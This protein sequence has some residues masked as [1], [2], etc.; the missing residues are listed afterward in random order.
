[1]H[2]RERERQLFKLFCVLWSYLLKRADRCYPS[3]V[4]QVVH[5]AGESG[6]PHSLMKRRRMQ[7]LFDTKTNVQRLPLSR[8]SRKI[9]TQTHFHTDTHSK[10]QATARS[11]CGCHGMLRT[12][13]RGSLCFFLMVLPC[14]IC[15]K[16]TALFSCSHWQEPGQRLFTLPTA[17]G[18]AGAGGRW[19]GIQRAKTAGGRRE[20]GSAE[21]IQQQEAWLFCF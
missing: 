21:L 7:L 10:Q 9:L 15:T 19:T 2:R 17:E 8:L 20:S 5:K 18:G 16:R 1:M 3:A 11:I 13:G 14:L 4:F 12:K 6:G